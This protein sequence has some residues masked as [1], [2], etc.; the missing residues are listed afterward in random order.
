M[1]N[2]YS[3]HAKVAEVNFKL[4]SRHTLDNIEKE[5]KLK[6]QSFAKFII[7]YHPVKMF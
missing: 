7:P 5:K 2:T 3:A 1:D 6:M 4:I